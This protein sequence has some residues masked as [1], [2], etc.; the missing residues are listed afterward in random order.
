VRLDLA[1]VPGSMESIRTEEA[2]MT[3]GTTHTIDAPGAVLTYDVRSGSDADKTPLLMVA[4]PMVVAGFT[5]L[6][7]HFTDR[8]VVTYDPR[9]SERSRLTSDA[10]PTP[11]TH[12]DDIHRVIQAAVGSGPVDVLGEQ[13]WRGEHAGVRRGAS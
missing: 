7:D 6:A 10:D 9:Q 11:E 13:R 2:Q 12:A 3:E 8:T 1:S 5:T 4:S